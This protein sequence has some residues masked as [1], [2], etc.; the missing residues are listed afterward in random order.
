LCEP[1]FAQVTRFKSKNCCLDVRAS[2]PVAALAQLEFVFEVGSAGTAWVDAM[3]TVEALQILKIK[4][5]AIDQEHDAECAEHEAQ[6]EAIDAKA[7]AQALSAVFDFLKD[8]KI[9]L[10]HSLLRIFRRYLRT[11]KHDIP[12][13]RQQRIPTRMRKRK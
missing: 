12:I 3:Q 2:E 8:C 9:A 1:V 13:D 7:E 5:A 11:S 10:P 4:L 6:R